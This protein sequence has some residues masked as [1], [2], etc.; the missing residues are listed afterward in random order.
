MVVMITLQAGKRVYYYCETCG[1]D[2]V[3]NI[4]DYG[5]E[6]FVTVLSDNRVSLKSV[7]QDGGSNNTADLDSVNDDDSLADDV[8]TSHNLIA[9]SSPLT[10]VDQPDVTV[11]TI[12][13]SDSTQSASSSCTSPSAIISSPN[14]TSQLAVSSQENDVSLQNR[15]SLEENNLQVVPPP[16]PTTSSDITP[17]II[18]SQEMAVP[19]QS[20][21]DMVCLS[22]TSSANR[23]CTPSNDHTPST[24]STIPPSDGQFTLAVTT[25]IAPTT[26]QNI[27]IST[28]PSSSIAL[29][30]IPTG[31]PLQHSIPSVHSPHVTPSQSTSSQVTPSQTV[32]NHLT[33]SAL[34]NTE[35][36]TSIAMENVS[37]SCKHTPFEHTKLNRKSITQKDENKVIFV[38]LII[39]SAIYCSSL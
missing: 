25:T 36:S 14:D 28:A 16:K 2:Y 26:T 8:D 22:T 21:V 38:V 6:D 1:E 10:S 9:L 5:P 15:H 27:A 31:G 7:P 32:S 17:S 4:D 34:V 30:D 11:V 13:L 24:V 23:S 29:P 20:Y 37:D 33:P 39:I 18:T 12:E 19:S 35:V 3:N